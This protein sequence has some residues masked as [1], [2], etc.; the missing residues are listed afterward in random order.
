MALRI[1]VRPSF[2]EE[3]RNGEDGPYYVTVDVYS[4]EAVDDDGH[5]WELLGVGG[6]DQ[7]LVEHELQHLDHDPVSRPDAWGECEP[8]YGSNAWD[9]ESEY[10]LA[11]FEADAYDEPRPDPCRF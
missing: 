4:I 10:R 1:Y 7:S 6:T 9:N 2:Y 8:V 11:C 5:V 3:R